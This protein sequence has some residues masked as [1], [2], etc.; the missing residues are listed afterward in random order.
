MA[1]Y[2][3]ANIEVKDPEAYEV[4]KLL[5]ARALARYG[6]R[7]LVRGGAAEKLEGD[8]QPRR[9]VLLEFESAARAK[10]WWNSP[11]YAPAKEIRERTARSELVLVEG[12]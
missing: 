12:I 9:V 1:A 7:F 10:E 11:E 2:V 6:G 5:A 3:I 8:W 4:Y